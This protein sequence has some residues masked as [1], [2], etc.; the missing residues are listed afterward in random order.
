MG[1]HSVTFFLLPE[2]ETEN[3]ASKLESIRG[4]GKFPYFRTLFSVASYWTSILSKKIF[5]KKA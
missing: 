2:L 3:S 1:I 5:I 4:E